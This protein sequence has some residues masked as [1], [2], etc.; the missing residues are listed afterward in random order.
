MRVTTAATTAAVL[1][2]MSLGGCAAASSSEH[3]PASTTTTPAVTA[4][5]LLA[6][7]E[8]ATLLQSPS[9][10]RPTM[11]GVGLCNYAE[12]IAADSPRI[13]IGY[14]TATAPLAQPAGSTAVTVDGVQAYWT[15]SGSNAGTLST[16]H[17]G[18]YV[19]VTVAGVS[20]PQQAAQTAL[21]AALS[22]AG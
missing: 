8:A 15:P 5:S 2:A 3:L 14:G 4:C 10:V 22:T 6:A 1:S 7:T 13:T 18:H 11:Q 16:V 19:N 21:S 17:H 12:T 20:K 9:P